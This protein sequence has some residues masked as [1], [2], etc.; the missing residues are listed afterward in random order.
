MES[1]SQLPMT[2]KVRL[3]DLL[4]L[5]DFQTLTDKQQLFVALYISSGHHTGTYNAADA[6]ARVY[7]TKD[8]KSAAALG[9]ELLGQRKIRTVL[10]LHF[11]RD[12]LA[13]LLVDLQ[14]AVKRGLRRGN[15]KFVVITPEVASA[16]LIFEA[17]V[18]AEGNVH[19]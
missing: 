3:A 19:E 14:R 6:A 13:G 7:R 2:K 8:T 5:P 15:K 12:A 10:D 18:S 17:Y 4:R 11:G 9:A 16:L 1:C